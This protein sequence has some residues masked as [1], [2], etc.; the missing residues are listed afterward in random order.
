MEGAGRD[1]TGE[2]RYDPLAVLPTPSFPSDHAII[3]GT[4]YMHQQCSAASQ[5]G[6]LCGT[7]F[8]SGSATC[9]CDACG[10]ALNPRALK[11]DRLPN[12]KPSRRTSIRDMTLYDYWGICELPLVLDQNKIPAV[13]P[14]A[15]GRSAQAEGRLAQLEQQLA[16]RPSVLYQTDPPPHGAKDVH[17]VREDWDRLKAR[18][19]ARRDRFIWV[20]FST[21]PMSEALCRHWFQLLLISVLLPNLWI[22]GCKIASTLAAMPLFDHPGWSWTGL[23]LLQGGPS[24]LQWFLDLVCSGFLLLMVPSPPPPS[25]PSPLPPLVVSSPLSWSLARGCSIAPLARLLPLSA[26]LA[27]LLLLVAALL[28]SVLFVLVAA[29]FLSSSWRL[30][31]SSWLLSLTTWWSP[32]PSRCAPL[33]Q[34]LCAHGSSLSPGL[35]LPPVTPFCCAPLSERPTA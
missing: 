1:N 17:A 11:E 19:Y 14:A 7:E 6:S 10:Y 32:A 33:S 20:L 18:A 5:S 27:A 30:S 29:L 8:A 2:Q 35:M 3:L 34:P 16:R 25:R 31:F 26:L 12:L 15:D 13:A 4:F 9:D 24:P 23:L 28:F 22:M 21:R